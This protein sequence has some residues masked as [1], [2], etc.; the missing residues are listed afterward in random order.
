MLMITR[1][2]MGIN[3]RLFSHGGGGGVEQGCPLSPLLFSIYLNY[4]DSVTGFYCEKHV[5][6]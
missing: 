2:Q 6:C 4:I 3:Q 5:V 1:W